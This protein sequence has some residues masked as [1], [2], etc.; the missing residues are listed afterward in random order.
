MGKGEKGREMGEAGRKGD[1][2]IN[3]HLLVEEEKE[4]GKTKR[5]RKWALNL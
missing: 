4:K 3:R 1:K 2:E 5:E